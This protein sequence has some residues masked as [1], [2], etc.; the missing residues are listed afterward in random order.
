MRLRQVTASLDE[1]DS[2]CYSPS[3]WWVTLQH[4]AIAR[5]CAA[6][7]PKHL[8]LK[9][10][11]CDCTKVDVMCVDNWKLWGLISKKLKRMK[12]DNLS[13][14]HSW[15]LRVPSLGT[16][17]EEPTYEFQPNRENG[18]WTDKCKNYVN[19]C[20]P[21]CVCIRLSRRMVH[22]NSTGQCRLQEVSFEDTLLFV[23][24]WYGYMC[25]W[26]RDSSNIWSRLKVP[27]KPG[28]PYRRHAYDTL[29]TK[30]LPQLRCIRTCKQSSHSDTP[31][32]LI[33][34]RPTGVINR[35]KWCPHSP[36]YD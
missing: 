31:V 5:W 11:A 20:Q 13:N 26:T 32:R 23:S 36:N 30:P 3:R 19:M 7:C 27:N 6:I 4:V 21:V 9:A 16:C 35:E 8:N 33:K 28:V 2:G 10:E 18:H 15:R 34:T 25:S 29:Y 22:R 17:Y 14:V 12:S 24:L 1:I